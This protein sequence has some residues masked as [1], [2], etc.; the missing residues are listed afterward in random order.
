MR[1]LKLTLFLMSH[2]VP[3]GICYRLATCTQNFRITYLCIVHWKHYITITEG[4]KNRFIH[5]NRLVLN[6]NICCP[7]VICF[8]LSKSDQYINLNF[9]TVYRLL[10]GSHKTNFLNLYRSGNEFILEKLN[11]SRNLIYSSIKIWL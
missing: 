6:L 10:T 3:K 2:T 7:I 5:K 4:F 11:C 9:C 1:I 8:F